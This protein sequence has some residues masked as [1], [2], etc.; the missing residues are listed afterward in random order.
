M[1]ASAARKDRGAATEGEATG[2]AFDWGAMDWGAMDWGAMDW[3][4]LGA[5]AVGGAGGG[6]AGGALARAEAGARGAPCRST[7]AGPDGVSSIAG[8]STTVRSSSCTGLP[9]APGGS[10]RRTRMDGLTDRGEVTDDALCGW[11]TWG[12]H[13][14]SWGSATPGTVPPNA[15]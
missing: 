4:A 9:R 12:T 1:D 14:G 13:W 3:G 5:D 6:V 7:G 10:G 11:R 8:R 15:D 2:G